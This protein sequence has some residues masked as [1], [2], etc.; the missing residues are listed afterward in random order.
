MHKYTVLV[1]MATELMTPSF[2]RAAPAPPAR[3]GGLP[4]SDPRRGNG[5]AALDPTNN[6]S[7]I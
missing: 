3:A 4:T 7:N 5:A 1:F 6:V 2:S